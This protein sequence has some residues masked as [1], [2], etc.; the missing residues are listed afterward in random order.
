MPRLPRRPPAPESASRRRSPTARAPTAPTGGAP[1]GRR[2]DVARQRPATSSSTSRSAAACSGVSKIGAVRAVDGVSFDVRRGE[3]LGLVGE[4]GCGKTTLG[5]VILRLIPSRR[6]ARS[7]FKGQTIFD[8]PTADRRAGRK[9][10]RASG[11]H[12]EDPARHAD[13]LPGPVRQPQPAHDGRRDHRRGPARPRAD[14]QGASARTLVREL[15]GQGRPQPEPH[16]PL[17][18]R[19]L[20]AAS[21]SASASPG[22]SRSTP[23]S[24]SATSPCRRLDV[25]IQSQVLNLLD[26]LQQELGLTYLFIAHNLAVVEHISDRVGVMYL[27]KIVELADVDDAVPQPAPPVHG[28]AAVGGPG[29]RPAHSARSGSCSRATSRRRPRRRRAAGSTPAAGCAS[30]WATRSAAR[31]RSR[32][33]ATFGP[34]SRWPATTPRR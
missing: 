30:A 26:D 5:K 32:C 29:A 8:I 22:R 31:P 16:P 9:A 17:P 2:G 27:G 28:G 7:T 4:S 3:T 14:G 11:K 24:S 19:V 10:Y 25:S 6:P 12:E 1:A 18:A 20:A 13:R 33:S 23:T 15:L 34:A 21:A